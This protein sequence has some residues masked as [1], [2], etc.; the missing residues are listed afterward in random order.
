M[1]TEL[2]SI[3]SYFFI[4]GCVSDSFNRLKAKIFNIIEATGI[5][6][7]QSEAIIKLIKGIANDEHINC[8]KHMRKV[9]LTAEIITDEEVKTFPPI[10]SNPL[11]TEV[12]E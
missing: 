4:E 7:K 2:E 8:S 12:Y 6:D 1:K 9:A 3:N 5:E 11:E 10:S